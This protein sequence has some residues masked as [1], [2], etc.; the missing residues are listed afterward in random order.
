MKMMKALI[1]VVGAA[2]AGDSIKDS[3]VAPIEVRLKDPRALIDYDLDYIPQHCFSKFEVNGVVYEEWIIPYERFFVQKFGKY[4]PGLYLESVVKD[5]LLYIVRAGIC[6]LHNDALQMA[7]DMTTPIEV[8]L[9]VIFPDQKSDSV[10]PSSATEDFT[11]L[12]ESKNFAYLLVQ[13]GRV[14]RF[15]ENGS[16]IDVK[17]YSEFE[18]MVREH[19][20]SLKKN[21]KDPRFVELMERLRPYYGEELWKKVIDYLR[22]K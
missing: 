13:D 19:D 18:R 15:Y 17:E 6:F 14:F 7:E 16:Q 9:K 22:W 20:K 3:K 4:P 11:L 21:S 1:F 5:S 8:P 2:F 12:D 10:W